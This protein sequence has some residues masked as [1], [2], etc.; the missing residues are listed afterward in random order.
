MGFKRRVL[1]FL[2]LLLPLLLLS[3]CT[4]VSDVSGTAD[5]PLYVYFIDVGQGDSILVTRD[6]SGILIDAGNNGDGAVVIEAIQ[7]A[8]LERLDYVI[9]THPHEDHIGGLD[10]VLRGI[11]ADNIIL[12][13]YET[14][15]KTARDLLEAIEETGVA[16][17]DARAGASYDLGGFRMDILAPVREYSDA[18]NNSVVAKITYGTTS[19]LLTGDIEAKAEKDI[20]DMGTDVSCD[21]LKSPHHGSGSASSYVFLRQS[22]PK[23]IVISCGV[24]NSYGHPHEQTLSRY[25]DLGATVYRTD[26]QGTVTMRS[27]GKTITAEVQGEQSDRPHTTDGGLGEDISVSTYIGNKNSQKFHLPECKSLPAGHNRIE[28]GSQRAAIDAGYEPCGTCKP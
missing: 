14:D 12:P 21:V 8:G 16:R 4:P 13:K 10:E 6:G 15:T 28:F 9:G 1:F 17:I 20:L 22:N 18:N 3:G 23:E 2:G 26:R 7:N 19:F 27:D 24:N 5:M 11:P 25:R